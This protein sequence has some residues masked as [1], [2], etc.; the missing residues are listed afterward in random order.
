MLWNA[1]IQLKN[2]IYVTDIEAMKGFAIFQCEAGYYTAIE[3]ANGRKGFIT[4]VRKDSRGKWWEYEVSDPTFQ[5]EVQNLMFEE[6]MKA[7][8]SLETIIN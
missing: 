6:Y 5:D 8:F 4:F 1:L 3:T 7:V 2:L